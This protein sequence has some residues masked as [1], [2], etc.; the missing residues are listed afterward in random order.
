MM[1]KAVFTLA[2]FTVKL[3][4]VSRHKTIRLTCLGHIG[5][6]NSGRITKNVSSSTFLGSWVQG[7]KAG[8][9]SVCF[10]HFR[11]VNSLMAIQLFALI[12]TS[13]F[14]MHFHSTFFSL[15]L[16]KVDLWKRIEFY[17][18]PIRGQFRIN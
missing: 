8:A 10:L 11:D 3:S 13:T 5:W 18:R 12:Y 6:P 7:A 16:L 15:K 14:A 2:K 1:F 4:V 9:A 17:T